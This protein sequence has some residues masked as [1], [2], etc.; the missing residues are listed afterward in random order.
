MR[1]QTPFGVFFLPSLAV[2]AHAEITGNA[3]DI[4]IHA[5]GLVEVVGNAGITSENYLGYGRSGDIRIVGDEVR[6]IDGALVSTLNGALGPGAD[7]R[8]PFTG[9]PDPGPPGGDM[10]PPSSPSVSA[11]VAVE[12]LGRP[13]R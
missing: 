11:A 13:H 12:S 5:T 1:R 9:R 4:D 10:L 8:P 7:P 2:G 3:G 6:L